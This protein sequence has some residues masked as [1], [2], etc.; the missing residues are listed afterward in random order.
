MI[1]VI[2]CGNLNRGD[3]G[4]GPTVIGA[5]RSR[6]LEQSGVR[7]FDAGVD[8]MA[9][10]FAA[11]GCRSLIIIDAGRSGSEPGAV[12]EVPGHELEQPHAPALNLHDFRWDHALHAGRRIFRDDFPS[13][14]VVLLVEAASLEFGIGLTPVVAR[15]AAAV[16]NRVEALVA[17]RLAAD[18]AGS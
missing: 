15:A 18:P 13:D 9:T 5:L 3:D 6:G 2:G 17:A 1:A 10:M 16:A 7:L 14:V 8:G 12:F 11:R 4:V